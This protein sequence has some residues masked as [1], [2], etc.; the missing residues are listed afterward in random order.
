MAV[1]KKT[2][3]A[4]NLDKYNTFVV[5]TAPN[6][7]YFN[8]TEIPDAFTGGKNAFL[9]AGSKE[10]VAD[11]LVKIEIK[12]AAG[13]TIYHEPGEGIVSSSI[14]GETFVTEYYEGVS[15][16][17]ALY[18]YPDTTAYGP[19]TI[20]ILGELSSYYDGNGLLTPI[21][22]DWQGTYNV[23]WQRTVNVNPTLANT[24]K[25]RF[26]KRPTATIRE[27]LSPIYR[28]ES[29]SKVDSGVNQSF[30]EIKLSQLE[31]FAGDVKRVKV[32]RTSEG[33]ISDF[34]LI[35]DI[36]VESK[37]LL[38][39]TQLS[40]SV[41][42]NTGTFTS[43]VLPLFWNTSSLT[44]EL[45]SSRVES[46][47]KLNGSGLL[48][49]SQSLNI[50]A[51]NTYELNLDAFY[52]SSTASNLGIYI[53]GSDGGDVLISTLNGITPTKNLLDTVVPFKLDSD[54]ES[55]SLY[56]SQ[57]QG[58]W[59]LGNISLRLSED[60]AFSP[61]EISFITTMPTVIGDETYNFKFEFY[62]VNNNFVP[63]AVTQSANFTGGTTGV[64]AKLL[65]FDSDRNA[66]RFST[67]S[68]GNPRFQTIGFTVGKTNLTGS[69]TY[70]RA[71]FDITGSY[72]D[73]VVYT[74]VGAVYPGEPTNP[75]ENGFIAHLDEFTGSISSILVGS[76]TYTAS[77][78][79]LHQ[80]ETIYRFEDGDN[81]PG[82]F[83]TSNTNQFIYKATD[84]SLNPTGQV[85]TIEA[86]RKNLASA[87]TPL[88]VNSGSGKPPLTFV[89][90]NTTNGVDTYTLAGT[91]YPFGTGETTYF[92]SGSDQ[93]GNEFSD[94]VKI[95]PVKIL[96]G[97]SVNLTNENATL[98]ALSTG[99]VTSAS[100]AA[101]SGSVSVKVG[102]EDISR[103]EG[104]TTNNRF[105]I[106]SATGVNCTPNDTTP[107]D[108]TY[109]ITT[110]TA[111]SGSLTL[112]VRY[113]DGAGDT[114]D[115]TK[116]VTY[117]KSKRGVPNVEVAV[118]P[119][120]QSIQSNSRGSGSAT[121]QTLTVTALEGGT[122]RFTSLGTPTYTNGLAGSVST[123]T[124][125]FSSNASSMTSDSGTV[126]IP[127][128]FT[129]SEGVS[130]T[131]NVTA[132][133]SRVRSS[134]PVVNISANPQSQTVVSGSLAGIGTPS[135]VTVVV[136]EG[137]SNYTYNTSGANTFNIT[138]VTN[139]TNNGNGTITPNTPTSI[140]GTSGVI[141]ISYRNSEGTTFTGRTID[142]EVGV[143]GIGN[144]GAAGATGATGAT[145]AAGANG[146]N[147]LR[148]AAGMVHYQLTTT[149]A[150]SGPSATSYTFS[151]GTFSGLTA[152][153]GTGAPTY[154]SGNTNKYWYAT[155]TAVETTPGGG[156]GTVSF[157]SPTQAIGFS[158]LVS[159]TSA[160]AVDNGLGN[161]LS[162]GVTGATLINGSNI[163]TGKII[164][165]NYSAGSPYTTA[166]SI[167]DL[168]NGRIA[169]KTF[170]V[171][172]NGDAVF[173]G[174]LSAAAGT[175]AG[176]LSAAAGT[177]TGAL[178]GGTISIGSG[179]S[180][181]K[182]D[183]NGIYLGNATFASAPF[184]VTPDGALT[185]TNANIT[186]TI[187]ATLGAI[188]G[189]NIGS[190]TISKTSTGTI[191][192][193]SN[194]L[195]FFIK[196]GSR[197]AVIMTD[198]TSFRI[199]SSTSALSDFSGGGG[200]TTRNGPIF[201][202][203]LQSEAS[204]TFNSN[205]VSTGVVAAGT[206][207]SM[208]DAEISA[209]ITNSLSTSYLMQIST[210]TYVQT[211]HWIS[212]EVVGVGEALIASGYVFY[213][214]ASYERNITSTGGASI[215]IA[216]AGTYNV[217]IKHQIGVNY[218][219][220]GE[221]ISLKPPN[222][223][224]VNA[225]VGSAPRSVEICQAGLQSLYG[226]NQFKV[227]T[228]LSA[229]NFLTVKGSS[230]FSGLSTF[231]T[232]NATVGA[233][234]NLSVGEIS[235]SSGTLT[236]NGDIRATGDIYALAS[237]DKRLK[238]NIIPISN[239]M[240]KIKKIGG[241]TFNWNGVSNKPKHIQ[242]VGVLAQEI[243]DVLPEVVK[244]KG[245]GY[246]GVDYE[247]II[248]LLIEGIKEQNGEIV[249]LKNE[250]TSIKKLLNK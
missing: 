128:N 35:Q 83:V 202:Q 3:F 199:G 219:I 203:N 227:D 160:N 26:Y 158:G 87:D 104:L 27:I 41:I 134:A 191:E 237:S 44:T 127:V 18:V 166:G 225:V 50:K 195:G 45:T 94:A 207:V 226:S 140:S 101:T 174:T 178:S 9:I 217:R 43:E 79:G 90:T 197:N 28:I 206:E 37:E 86:K 81:A 2:L 113:K 10:L 242:E 14:D 136:N 168:D 224:G 23:K 110:L 13:N 105:D 126:T 123:N 236:I 155:Y 25:I 184:R 24:T 99:F 245:D 116:V 22:I 72:I 193:N 97:L 46:G 29:G 48:T 143:S 39:T 4:E 15:K 82:V 68:I 214:G 107:D 210:A 246:L 120:A 235:L 138:G 130:G 21:P 93:F 248:A 200:P 222:F 118:T 220:S 114:T 179:N 144:T 173:K 100:F 150:P 59:H 209:M 52:S 176:T 198:D 183:S 20:T 152:N 146:T 196:D 216:S 201:G 156:T 30:A 231:S 69:V 47:L 247:K 88:T 19:C 249:E 240:D 49:Y 65:T 31:T 62:D 73:P 84:L 162:F 153:W 215:V 51:S 33:D 32:F 121:P 239:P 77:C 212:L 137:G 169:T 60:T 135:N 132:T 71:V 232:L 165:T 6:S 208:T 42:G 85:I 117:S 92:I 40:G 64:A 75:N 172:S 161:S 230:N 80:H 170:Y 151:N 142:F 221:S 185:A 36:L 98:P 154:A 122:T 125:V 243:Q 7:T 76:I 34:N 53:S 67:G 229:T 103:Q 54:F 57:S 244:E 228:S 147:G 218:L 8:V 102:A 91:A 115:V 131:K 12:D 141:T 96:D 55:G 175:F 56:F 108:A 157:G 111:D 238:E 211:Y 61:D 1:I 149:S 177:F 148:T 223:T 145:G 16:V 66:F 189:W 89:S 250:I 11:T 186:G 164:S 205:T 204:T 63:V 17:V 187:T 190:D 109:G 5:D 167:I 119:T 106:I 124:I 133:I 70:G 182:A 139:A 188:A 38:T 129:D 180:I 78:E 181:F 194:D 234:T 58:E 163:S 233:I 159:F 171:D 95:T 74:G 112:L 241:Y 192:I 213:N